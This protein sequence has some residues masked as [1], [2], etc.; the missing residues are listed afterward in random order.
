VLLLVLLLSLDGVL[1]LGG[2]RWG[3]ERPELP[4]LLLGAGEFAET[5][6]KG[7]RA[8]EELSEFLSILPVGPRE[9]GAA[10]LGT[11]L[12]DGEYG[13]LDETFLEKAPRG[14]NNSIN[15]FSWLSIHFSSSE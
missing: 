2:T 8:E 3:D 12:T 14:G 13:S 9:V 11:F 10:I 5:A 1:R 15:S 4:T 7:G 6:S